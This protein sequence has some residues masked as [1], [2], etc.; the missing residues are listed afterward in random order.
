M[1]SVPITMTLWVRIPP[2]LGVLDA[3]LCD[4]VYQWLA[5]GRRFFPGTPVSSTNKSD[6]HDI[7][8]ILLKV[9]LKTILSLTLVLA[10]IQLKNCSTGVKQESLTHL[11]N[12]S[13]IFIDT[14]TQYVYH[15]YSK[16]RLSWIFNSASSLKDNSP[17]VD[18]WCS[19]KTH[20]SDSEP[21]NLCPYSLMWCA[22]DPHYVYHIYP[23]H[24]LLNF[25][26][27]TSN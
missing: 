21:I 24:F 8:E 17:R 15:I 14:D 5:V 16:L 19:T 25:I 18:M 26:L 2:R 7:A 3:T 27:L 13:K 11:I 1:Q 23:K 12:I 4:K 9:V 10:M 6:H 22:T 20:Y